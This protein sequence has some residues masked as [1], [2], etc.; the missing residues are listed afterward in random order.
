MRP[1]KLKMTAFGAY[2]KPVELDFE[3]GLGG[4]N[5]FLIHGATGSGKTTIL[6]GMVY[7]LYGDSSGGNRK[8]E[9]MRSDGAMPTEK[10]EV[11]FT[12]ALRGNIYKI[13]RSQAY[14]RPKKNGE[15]LTD[16]KAIAEIFV[17][18][19]NERGFCPIET[20]SVKEYVGSLIGFNCEQFRQVVVLPQGAF[21][22]FLMSSSKE[23]Q[24][25]LNILFN[26]EFFKRVEIDLKERL[27][28]AKKKYDELNVK[29]NHLIEDAITLT[30]AEKFKPEMFDEFEEKFTEE[31]TATKV[32]VEKLTAA[33]NAA[34]KE[35]AA[36]E[37][38]AKLFKDVETKT[39]ALIEAQE[40]FKKF[41][42]ALAAAKVEFDKRT[43]EKDLRD[44][45]T[46]EISELE[47]KRDAVKNM[48]TEKGKLEQ[49]EKS[50]QAA[51][52]EVA[53]A[54]N[55]KRR[56]DETMTK[57]K[58]AA[59]KL[60]DAPAK[61]EVA[62]QR[63]RDAQSR[64]TLQEEIEKLGKK[65]SSAEKTA[66]AAT[67]SHDFAEEKLTKLRRAQ[68]DGSAARLAA[69]LTE[70]KPCPV[71]GAIHHPNPTISDKEI[72]TDNEIKSAEAALRTLADK[73]ADAEKYLSQLKGELD[74]KKKALAEIK[75]VMTVA[76]AKE[77]LDKVIKDV[78]ALNDFNRRIKNGEVKIPEA[79]K[80]LNTAR[81]NEKKISNEVNKIRGT[82]EEMSRNV[83]EKYL[84][85]PKLLDDKIAE[86]T[87][88]VN[89]LNTAF[90]NA[91]D[92]FNK[93]TAQNSAQKAK[94][95]SAQKNKDEVSAQIK[96]KTLPNVDALKKTF[97]D[98]HAAEQAAVEKKTKTETNL[99]RLKDI[100][101][102]VEDLAEDLKA[103]DKNC[104][105]WKTLSDTANG[106]MQK[107]ISFQNYYLATMFREVIVEA[108][109]R[110]EK[111]SG[112][113]FRFKNKEGVARYGAL[114]G[115]DLEI[116][117]DYTGTARE[118]ATLSGGESFLASL[119]LALGLAAVVQNNSGGI[120]LDTIF[121]DEG[122]GTLDTETLDFAMKTLMEL[123]SGGRLVGIISHVEELKNQMPVRLEVT[124]TKNGSVARFV[125]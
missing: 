84:A 68:I 60:K 101:K 8:A 72:P 34:N 80:R 24:G 20:K 28:N 75:E 6:D 62:E 48:Q 78:D 54:E 98:N 17:R 100:R 7:A 124:K 102:N 73:K 103:A 12:F 25:V 105:M 32:Q 122:F 56:C 13:V 18:N 106:K 55:Y 117:D 66:I 45:L 94:V 23:R 115:L 71:C 79:E 40:L 92:N 113:R 104:L 46:L 9:M 35:Y 120:R 90:K 93:L 76:E 44:K 14:K 77:N 95:E 10:T 123:Q 125:S 111:M 67:K 121:I 65:I 49:A 89:E 53:E 27:D 107:K 58:T 39:R 74:A 86:T 63:L 109:N 69:T 26:A 70:G 50:A 15:G 88:Q 51:I 97:D 42:S 3:K 47:K 16:E 4:E 114:S 33:T 30:G 108:N 21:Q 59:E 29:Q 5:F 82:V 52:K 1:I 81:D 119:S 31:L 11:E 19:E 22:K 85:N 37:N 116:V 87:R 91:Q 112:G 57:Y 61:K 36:A 64:Q 99:Q 83:D 110:L 41:S 118:V 43:A 2:L 38:V 96:G